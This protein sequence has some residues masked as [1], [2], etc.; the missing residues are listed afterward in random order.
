MQIDVGLAQTLDET[1]RNPSG[2]AI[3]TSAVDLL[4]FEGSSLRF[5][6]GDTIGLSAAGANAMSHGALARRFRK[7]IAQHQAAARFV[8]GTGLRRAGPGKSWCDGEVAAK[9][10]CLTLGVGETRCLQCNVSMRGLPLGLA[11]S[12]WTRPS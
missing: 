7:G 9:I 1:E 12:K 6:S 2:P 4:E 8:R 3:R 10:R 11:C 5:V